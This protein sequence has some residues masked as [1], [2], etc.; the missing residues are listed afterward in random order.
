MNRNFENAKK[1]VVDEVTNPLRCRRGRTRN[2]LH[3]GSVKN[4]LCLLLLL[5]FSFFVLTAAAPTLFSQELGVIRIEVGGGG[6][7]FIDGRPLQ[8]NRFQLPQG[9]SESVE[10]ENGATLKTDPD[11]E[12]SL[13][14]AER[15][16]NDG[17]YRVA[18]QL[19]QAILGRSGDAL[20]SSDGVTYFSLVRQVEKILADLPPEGLAAYRV[21]ADAEAKEILAAANGEHDVVALNQVV[22]NY[23]LSSLGDDAAFELGCLYL[24]QFDFTGARRMFEKIIQNYPDPSVPLDQ[25]QLRIALCQSYLGQIE[26]AEKSLAVATELGN[27]SNQLTQ[28]RQSLGDLDRQTASGPVNA[29]W[30]MPLGDSRRYGV[31]PRLPR[32]WLKEDVAAKWQFYFQPDDSYTSN[33]IQGKLLVG[34]EAN[35]KTAAGTVDPIEESFIETWREKNWRPVGELLFDE[36]RVYFK[37]GADL[38][39]FDSAKIKTMIQSEPEKPAVMDVIDWRSVWRNGFEVDE[40]TQMIQTI[41]RSWGG[42]GN[43]GGNVTNSGVPESIAQVQLFGDAIHSQ[44]SIY[45]GMVFSIEGEAYNDRIKASRQRVTPQWNA[46]FRRTRTNFLTAYDNVTGQVRWTLP[47]KPADTNRPKQPSPDLPE[48]IAE[49]QDSPFLESGGFMSAPI[50]F[51]DLIIVPVN[52]GGAISVYA[53]DPNQNGKTVWKSFLCDEPES[54]AES[55][56]AIDLTLDGSD[57]FV[58]TGMGVVF[59]LDPATG[60][61]RFAKRYKRVGSADDFRRRSGWTVNRLNFSGWSSDKII[62]FGRQM[63]CF[64]SDND[65]IEA[66]DRNNGDL[67]WRSE[68]SPI[69]YKVDYVLGVFDGLLYVAGRETIVAYDLNGEGRMVWGAEQMFDDKRSQGRGVLT[70]G[71]LYLPVENSIYHFSLP[72][73]DQPGKLQSRVQAHLG[74]GAPVGNLYSDGQRLWVHGGNRLYALGPKE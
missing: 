71:G 73:A 33:D 24:D 50:G 34:E 69:G 55:W 57:L 3:D 60:L 52:N 65:Q 30:S 48:A 12:A 17:N 66:Y 4:S 44:M 25:V 19:W 42:Y 46:S 47:N 29:N 20:Y 51:G 27:N 5:L 41:R 74:S 26:E 45:N 31:M 7:G 28:I 68:M 9:D 49:M 35:N 10:P 59:V 37:T 63:I 40:A 38:A 61:V 62:P 32:D 22:R 23:F 56:S 67:I 11:L 8:L 13:E 72:T 15:F 6:M 21:L 43:R 1:T 70:P 16:K 36:G 64:S 58:N 18:T 53:L 54:G 2:C 39:V 14:T